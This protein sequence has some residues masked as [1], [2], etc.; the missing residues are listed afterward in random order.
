[1]RSFNLLV[2][3]SFHGLFRRIPGSK[4]NIFRG[5]NFC[6]SVSVMSLH[7]PVTSGQEISPSRLNLTRRPVNTVYSDLHIMSVLCP[8]LCFHPHPDKVRQ[9]F[10]Q[11]DYRVRIT[12]APYREVPRQR[13][14]AGGARSPRRDPFPR[15]VGPSA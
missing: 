5:V 1:M 13:A 14:R 11:R 6:M 8:L 2:S 15:R 9:T 3:K 12:G 10:A 4:W 7:L